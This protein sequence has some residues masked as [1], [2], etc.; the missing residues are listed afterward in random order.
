[1]CLL[2]GMYAFF[3]PLVGAAAI[4]LLRVYA[5]VHTQYWSLILG[6]ILALVIIFLPD[7]VLGV[8]ARR[9]LPKEDRGA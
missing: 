3:G 2:G 9:A 7:G 6:T 8:F 5:S 1:M 4:V